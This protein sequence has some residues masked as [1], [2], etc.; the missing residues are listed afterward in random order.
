[1]RFLPLVALLIACTGAPP[2]PSGDA[3]EP[4]A[5]RAGPTPEQIAAARRYV[6]E[7]RAWGA[8]P[9][10]TEPA[11]APEVSPKD[12]I[13]ASLAASAPQAMLDAETAAKAEAACRDGSD[14]R[15]CITAASAYH[16]GNPS[17][18]RP[19][20]PAKA[21]ELAKLGC[22]RG[23]L[24]A[25]AVAGTMLVQ[26]DGTSPTE[27]LA[28]FDLIVRSCDGGHGNGCLVAAS[29][30]AGDR[31]G[32]PDL[33]RAYT[34]ARKACDAGLADGCFLVGAALDE[35]LEGADRIADAHAA[36]QRAC[37]LG[38]DRA[39][40]NLVLALHG[41]ERVPEDLP[42]A[43]AISEAGC[44]RGLPATCLLYG[45]FLLDGIGGPQDR[46]AARA[47]LTTACQGGSVRACGMLKE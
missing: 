19:A 34:F 22:D 40:S 25:C 18:V 41:G 43:R 33:N 7:K 16:P 31:I 5:T 30:L 45:T 38:S 3:P 42:R 23:E 44:K 12:A 4:G 17:R 27:R 9:A 8:D 21:V 24:A 11:P 32:P 20:N 13:E 15:A 35:G 37:D 28:G 36:Y 6:D 1:M 39:C 26:G 46:D 14:P 47:A 2:A 10:A 29:V